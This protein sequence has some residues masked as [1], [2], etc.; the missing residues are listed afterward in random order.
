MPNQTVASVGFA[1]IEIE[2]AG[3]RTDFQMILA[4]GR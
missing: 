2:I 1:F 3:Q 4:V